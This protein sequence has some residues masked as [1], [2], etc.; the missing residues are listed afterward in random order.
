[1]NRFLLA[2]IVSCV[3]IVSDAGEKSLSYADAKA[4]WN[5]NADS[6]AYQTYAAEFSQFNNHFQLDVKDGC[7]SKSSGPVEMMLVIT[8]P[9]K[10]SPYAIIEDVISDVTNAKAECF[11]RTY[12]GISTKVPP[13]LPFVLQMTMN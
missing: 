4:V 9:D 12:K 10:S 3:S 13:F 8:H 1:M 11:K 5:K 2:V 6:P 7:Y